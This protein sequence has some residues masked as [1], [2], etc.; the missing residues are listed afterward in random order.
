ML[1]INK[2]ISLYKK[3]SFTYK[4]KNTSMINNN[5]NKLDAKIISNKSFDNPVNKKLS[6]GG[7]GSIIKDKLSKLENK[8]GTTFA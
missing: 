1:G 6:Y 5:M 7:R 4:L 2:N 8:I 3:R